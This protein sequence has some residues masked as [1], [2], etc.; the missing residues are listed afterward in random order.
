MEV[1]VL[2][3]PLIFS[4]HKQKLFLFREGIGQYACRVQLKII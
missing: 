1:T 4:R 2:V 3:T